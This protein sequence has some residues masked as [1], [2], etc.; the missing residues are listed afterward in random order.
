MKNFLLIFHNNNNSTFQGG[1]NGFI[2]KCLDNENYENI[3][4]AKKQEKSFLK[5]NTRQKT[6]YFTDFLKSKII[7]SKNVFGINRYFNE[8]RKLFIK[9]NASGFKLIF[10]HD[11]FTLFNV[12]DMIQ[13]RQIVILQSHSPILPFEE[14]F[15]PNHSKD[16]IKIQ[17]EIFSR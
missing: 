1:P 7:T 13:E 10:F 4:I 5:L 6:L 16:L 9:S 15:G 11:I 8:D 12:I 14:L 2:N 17:S 3:I